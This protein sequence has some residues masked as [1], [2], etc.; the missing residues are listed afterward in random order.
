VRRRLWPGYPAATILVA[1]AIVLLRLVPDVSLVSA[2]LLLQLTVFFSAWIWESGPGVYSAVLATLGFNYFFLPPLHT[3]TVK[4]PRNVVALFVFL[5][6]GLLIGRLS[7]L[8]RQRL[9]QVEAERRDLETVTRLSRAFLA[10]TNREELFGIV[11]DRFR[12]ALQCREVVIFRDAGEG[13]LAVVATTPGAQVRED[14]AEIAFR[15]G[16]SADFPSELGGT[17]I[18]LPIPVGVVRVGVLAARGVLANERVAEACA[19]LLGLSIERESF[20]KAARSAESL[21][22]RDEMKST[23]LATLAHDLKTPVATARAAVE[24]WASRAGSAEEAR[25]ARGELE[26]L[27]RRV[28][29]LLQLVRLDANVARPHRERVTCAEILE[30]VVARFGQALSD[31]TLFVDPGPSGLAVEVDPVQITE[32]LGQGVEN[33]AAYSPAGSPIRISAAEADGRALLRVEDTGPGIPGAD[34][35]RVFD[36]F[37]RLTATEK[38]PGTGL[39]LAVARGL[40]EMNGGRV[41]LETPAGKGTLFVIDLPKSP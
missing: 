34:R 6:S 33:A 29:D 16:N 12:Q 13:R 26:A 23:L 7:S 3:F 11:A 25:V 21:R 27:T 8:A 40:V 38:V 18:Y 19:A 37:V 36:R 20:V 22:A 17:D 9:R 24:N 35:E 4:D 30:A 32:A 1:G 15:Q 28:E 31:H 5:I 14:L 10:D 2:A 41:S 39:G